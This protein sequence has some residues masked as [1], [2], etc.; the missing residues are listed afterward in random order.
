MKMLVSP[1]I[2][3]LSK[4]EE[5]VASGSSL[6]PM[7]GIKGGTGLIGGK[8]EYAPQIQETYAPTIIKHEP[9]ETYA[10]Q[11]QFAP[12]TTYGYVGATTLIE[13]PGAQVKKQQIMD[14]VSKPH[15]RGEWDIPTTIAPTIAPA[16]KG[17]TTG[18]N[19]THIAIIAV[20]GAAGIMLIKKKGGRR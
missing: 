9:Y 5:L 19:V 10:P 17:G 20:I 12:V 11:V 18:L 8:V 7:G 14:V 3:G 16:M 2:F 6:L 15:M 4:K 1:F 13:S